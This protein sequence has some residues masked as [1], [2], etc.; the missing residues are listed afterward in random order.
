MEG[1]SKKKKKRKKRGLIDMDN[2]GVTAGVGAVRG[3]KGCKGINGHGGN[4]L[5]I[6]K[7]EV[8]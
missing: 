6:F 4:T 5:K 2:S 7:K 1:F 8:F 3:E